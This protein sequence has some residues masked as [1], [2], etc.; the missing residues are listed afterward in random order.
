MKTSLL[1]PCPW[2]PRTEFNGEPMTQLVE[3]IKSLGILEPLIVRT[4]GRGKKC[5]IVAGERRYL[6]AKK[7]K[8]TTVPVIVRELSDREARELT[9]VENLQRE[10]LN[11]IDE[12]RGFALLL[13][14]DD[15]PTQTQLA[16][17]LGCS[18]AHIAN[19]LRLLK[20]PADWHERIISGRNTLLVCA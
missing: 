11:P 6:A 12:A 7:A 20:L 9:V 8:L 5:Q 18:Q 15:A 3:S 17:R 1:E 2:N 10:D 16:E 4:I 13:E 19:R 14:G